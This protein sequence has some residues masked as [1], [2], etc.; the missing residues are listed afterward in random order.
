MA[1][2][3]NHRNSI[4]ISEI[5]DK[6]DPDK[7]VQLIRQKRGIRNTQRIFL[8]LESDS[9]QSN[10]QS[11]PIK[12]QRNIK[13]TEAPVPVAAEPTQSENICP[14]DENTLNLANSKHSLSQNVNSEKGNDVSDKNRSTRIPRPRIQ[15]RRLSQN[16]GRRVLLKT[17]EKTQQNENFVSVIFSSIIN[18]EI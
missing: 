6:T 3:A 2:V 11:F 16:L 8:D 9:N 14:A 1:P 15:L 17:F 18:H 12:V 7:L 4:S 13:E 10:R 5:L